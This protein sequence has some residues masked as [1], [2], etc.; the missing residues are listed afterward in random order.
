MTISL[1]DK[2][3][4][5]RPRPSLYLSLYTYALRV[6]VPRRPFRALCLLCKLESLSCFAMSTCPVLPVR[7]IDTFKPVP[8]VSC[9]PYDPSDLTTKTTTTT[10][11]DHHD[12]SAPR[13]LFLPSTGARRVSP[14]V[15]DDY[16]DN[17]SGPT[18]NEELPYRLVV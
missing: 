18:L 3:P 5:S 17:K 9:L 4:G 16:D 10:T 1:G 14:T 8:Q 15:D 11:A 13:F 2:M 7:L 12:N 6:L